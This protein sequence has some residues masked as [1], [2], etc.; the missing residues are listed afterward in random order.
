V[1]PVAV[2]DL[3]PRL[4]I[5]EQVRARQ[6]APEEVEPRLLLDGAQ[7]RAEVLDPDVVA[8]VALARVPHRRIEQRPLV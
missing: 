4:E 1:A 6:D 5:D 3:E 8:E 2:G 7:Q